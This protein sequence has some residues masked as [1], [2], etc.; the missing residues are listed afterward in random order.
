[1][2]HIILIVNYN[3]YQDTLNCVKSIYNLKGDFQIVIVDNH[4]TNDAYRQLT[5]LLGHESKIHLCQCPI[6][7][8]Y[9]KGIDY[10]YH[11]ILDQNLAFDFIHVSNSDIVIEDADF[12]NKVEARYLR[13]PFYLLGPQVITNGINTSPIGYFYDA[14]DFMKEMKKLNFLAHGLYAFSLLTNDCFENKL[15]GQRNSNISKEVVKK[16]N[17]G[18][19]IFPILSGCYLIFSK[20]HL[21]LL[22]YLYRPI[23]FLYNEEMLITYTLLKNGIKPVAISYDPDL[24]VMHH[25][26]GSSKGASRK[27]AK[28][29]MENYRLFKQ[30]FQQKNEH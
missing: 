17:Q 6:N 29:V 3:N 2:K 14:S 20:L 28:F 8:G 24:V 26:G 13:K 18:E 10:A 19:D 7:L 15:E 22:G 25:H 23:T 11:Y 4:S 1:M 5:K 21:D 9:S 12:L 27:K 16:L 30:L